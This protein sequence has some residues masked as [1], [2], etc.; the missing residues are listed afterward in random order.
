[1]RPV[2]ESRLRVRYAETDQM[3][4]VYHSNHLIW[5]EVGR[6]DLC[7]VCGFNYRDM[8][9]EDGIFLAVAEA[10]CRYKSPARFDD[11]V[12]IKTWIEDANT[13]IVIFNYEMKVEDRLIATGMTRH[14]FVNSQM[15]RARMPQ[16]Y[17]AMFG[18]TGS[19]EA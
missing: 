9:R 16:K 13:R 3:G 8:E 12:V 6:V 19:N 1:M 15:Q 7:R 17:Y 5:M 10:N 2:S 11:E 18:I 14:V 4:V